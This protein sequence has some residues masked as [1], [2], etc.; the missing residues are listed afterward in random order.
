MTT[1]YSKSFEELEAVA[2][3]FWPAELS[4]IESKLSIIPLLLKTQDQFI[5]IISIETPSLQKLFTVIEASSLPSNLFLKHLAILADFGGEML[6]RVSIEFKTLFP[7]GELHYLW[8]GKKRTYK[9][10]ALPKQKFS[11]KALKIDGKELLNAHP[12]DDLQKDAIALLLFGS[13]YGNESGE[14]ALALSKCRLGNCLGNP[15]L[16]SKLVKQRYFWFSQIIRGVKT[17]LNSEFRYVRTTP[18]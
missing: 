16:V 2:S 15:S 14:V 9:F 7:T 8:R 17:S 13:A 6:Q 1:N 12:L 3:K 4:E 5:N 11:N 18:K 10:S